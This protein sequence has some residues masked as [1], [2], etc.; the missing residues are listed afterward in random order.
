MAVQ[1]NFVDAVEAIVARADDVQLAKRDGKKR[2]AL[3]IAADEG[4]VDIVR[5]LLGNMD[6]ND[7]WN[8]D[9]LGDT[10]LH[11]ATASAHRD[12]VKLLLRRAADADDLMIQNN[13]RQTAREVAVTRRDK[14]IIRLIEDCEESSQAGSRE[15]QEQ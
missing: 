10:A 15:P 5:I 12:V 4:Y 11:K 13:L 14:R 8:A 2:T 3:H 9:H 7:V 1:G 6:P